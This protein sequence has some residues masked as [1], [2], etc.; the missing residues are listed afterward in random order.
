MVRDA[1]SGPQV[2]G[3]P[4]YAYAA[5]RRPLP[6]LY[7]NPPCPWF[8]HS[9]PGASGEHHACHDEGGSSH[10]DTGARRTGSSTLQKHNPIVSVPHSSSNDKDHIPIIDLHNVSIFSSS[11]TQHAI[12]RQFS[13]HLDRGNHALIMGP[14]GCGKSTLI[15]FLC[16]LLA[17]KCNPIADICTAAATGSNVP[18]PKD[19]DD[20]DV[21]VDDKGGCGG[22]TGHVNRALDINSRDGD[23]A[24][25]PS[26]YAN[27]YCSREEI[28]CIP[29]IP[30]VFHV[31]PSSCSM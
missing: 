28:M 3:N 20:E 30:Y 13:F 24:I 19:D 8:D 14:S 22:V 29:Q 7:N 18:L 23:G 6:R 26:S 11:G 31:S 1:A 15:K 21:D 17:Y 2:I 5:Y 4:T 16:G 12:L 9:D 10:V 25:A 27:I